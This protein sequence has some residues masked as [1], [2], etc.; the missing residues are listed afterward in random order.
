MRP[1]SA[2]SLRSPER[3]RFRAPPPR[4]QCPAHEREKPDAARFLVAFLLHA[5]PLIGPKLGRTARWA[6]DYDVNS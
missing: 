5:A 6:Q 4:Y 2:P 3:P 1:P